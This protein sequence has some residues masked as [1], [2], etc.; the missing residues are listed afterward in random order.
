L[1]DPLFRKSA[2]DKLA[3]PER[4]DV[5]MHVTSPQ[6]WIALFTIGLVLAAVIGWSV[7]GR[8]G[9]R[10]NGQGLL[11]RGESNR[12]VLAGGGGVLRS[13]KVNLGDKVTTNQVVAEIAGAT[14]NE[15][16]AAART[17]LST[18]EGEHERTVS[19]RNQERLTIQTNLADLDTQLV[20]VRGD[21]EI[22]ERRQPERQDSLKKQ[23]ISQNA[24]DQFVQA[25]R[26]L[27]ARQSSLESQRRQMNLRL[28]NI[29]NEIAQ[30]QARL[31]NERS[32]YALMLKGLGAA[33]TVTS[34]F[35]GR[36]VNL[37]KRQGDA[38]RQGEVI[39]VVEESNAEL[40]AALFVDDRD[41]PRVTND[42]PVQIDL[43]PVVQREQYGVLLGKV[44]QVG[45]FAATPAEVLAV[46]GEAQSKDFLQRGKFLVRVALQPDPNT[47]TGFAWSS[48]SGPSQP[49]ASGMSIAGGAI[50]VGSQRPVCRVLPVD[51]LCAS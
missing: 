4:L 17:R 39:A 8:L 3:S 23:I 48:S 11:I 18:A 9:E 33:T 6:G 32:N 43:S 35:S 21:L 13:L 2:L 10:V 47:P 31:T 20:S 24:Y 42:M 12:L 50:I 44:S 25:L 34:L 29:N 1:A 5:L 41:G 27:E 19:G 51:A 28:S 15:E 40:Q 30:S 45:S 49:I 38:I 37:P 22:Q 36:I 16:L 46:L 7:F 14:V 26:V